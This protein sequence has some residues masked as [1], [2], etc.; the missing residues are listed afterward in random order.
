MKSVLQRILAS[1]LGVAMFAAMSCSQPGGGTSGPAGKPENAAAATPVESTEATETSTTAPSE[2][3][4]KISKESFGKIPDGTEVDRYT[5]TNGHGMKVAVITYGAMITS[6]ET[7]DRNGKLANITLYRDSLADYLAGHPFF[8]CVAGRYANRIAKGKFTLDG[9]EYTLATNN[10]ANHLHGGTKGFDKYVWKAR[11]VEGK[12]FVG[13][14]LSHESPDGDEGYPGKLSATVTYT[15]TDNNELKMQYTATTDKP[16][17]VNLTNHAYW[18]LAGAGS[19]D[20]LKQ[21]V[22]LN[23]DQFL[24]VD[25]GLIPL[26]PPQK[27]EGTPMDFTEPKTIGSR[28][29]Q[30]PGG[31]DHCYVLRKIGE[32]FSLAARVVEPTSGRVMEVYTTQPAIQFY[33]G[34]FLDGSVTGGGVAYQKHFGFCLET[35]HYPD[36]PNRSEYPSTL[37]KPGETYSQVTVYKFGVEK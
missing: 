5:L 12:G 20:V 17:H 22:M 36:S 14:A 16:T 1:V 8:G 29:E 21:V 35:E 10:G 13:V 6:V 3:S 2:T 15:L 23:A 26:G 27:V 30:V 32:E 7:P 28:I 18:N 33:T 34:N 19:G 4:M 9:V 25:D 37:L 31:Y 24:P 11:P